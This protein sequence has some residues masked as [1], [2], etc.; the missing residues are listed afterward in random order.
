MSPFSPPPRFTRAIVRKPG[1]S[2][3]HGITTADLGV[4]D[5]ERALQ[6]H[7][8]YVEALRGCGLQ[9]MELPALED[10]PDSTF[11][12]DVALCTRVGAV[13]TNPGAASRNGE[14]AHIRAALEAHFAT[15]EEIVAPGTLDAGDVMMV[16]DHFCIGLSARTN[17]EGAEQL[18]HILRSWGMEGEA[19]PLQDVLHLKTGVT[20]MEAG[21]MLVSGEFV[22][23]EVF[24]RYHRIQVPVEEA[25]AA[26][27]VWINDRILIPAGFPRVAA[28]LSGLGYALLPLEMSEFEK[29]DGGLSCLSLRF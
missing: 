26:N 7:A 12:E 27:C 28:A 15:L 13:V 2:L 25:Y 5:Y 10:F 16:G 6:Q 8:A 20:Y 3:V 9:V 23:R 11:V 4:P 14:R 19:V 17:A 21:N 29:L 22:H 24:A 18:I 1:R